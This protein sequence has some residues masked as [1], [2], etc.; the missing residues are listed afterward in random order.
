MKKVPSL[1]KGIG[2]FYYC[3]ISNEVWR[4]G[5]CALKR[6]FLVY[7]VPVTGVS[8][9]GAVVAVAVVAAG[10]VVVV[11]PPTTMIT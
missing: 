9:G 5:S 7:G 8:V 10:V 11:E 2:T 3:S 6:K 4:V 1:A